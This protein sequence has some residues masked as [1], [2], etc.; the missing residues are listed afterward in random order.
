MSQMPV[1]RSS[2]AGIVGLTSACI[3]AAMAPLPTQA[4]TGDGDWQWN[5]TV[6]LWLPSL[7]GETSFPPDGDGPSIDVSADAILDSL[8][9][10]FM[11]AFEGRRG[12]WGFAT[13]VI[14]LDLGA[15]EKATR[16]F[17]IGQAEIPASVNADLRLDMTG[18]L[19]TLAGSYAVVEQ[20]GLSV[21]VL[22]GA[23]MLDL[24][25]DLRWN[26]N[27]DISTLPVLDSSGS[28]TT[29]DTQWDAIV[30][31]KGRVTF[32]ADRQWYVPYYLDV[33]TGDSDLTW[34]G[35]AGVG[36]SFD[37]ID[38][39]GVWRYLDYDLGDST[40]IKSIDFNGAALGVTFRF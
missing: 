23:R 15:S 6:Y 9:F 19:W 7:G 40:P 26:I 30:G 29:K 11:G 21:N 32:G 12:P 37:S 16:D 3:L 39:T 28:S 4:A 27:G 33:G 5:A 36:Y 20:D 14:Y 1:F 8:N 13:D 17:G 18:W 34:Q 31:V 38:V 22:A 35:M 24:Q 2:I 10:A 25:E